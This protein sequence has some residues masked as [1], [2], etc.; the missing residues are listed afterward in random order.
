[1]RA[2][3][4]PTDNSYLWDQEVRLNDPLA[5]VQHQQNGPWRTPGTHLKVH[6]FDMRL[7]RVHSDRIKTILTR[8]IPPKRHVFKLLIQSCERKY[9]HRESSEGTALV[10][11][12]LL[13]RLRGTAFMLTDTIVSYERSIVVDAT[14]HKSIQCQVSSVYFIR[15]KCDLNVVC[16]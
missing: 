10:L 15:L 8:C 3:E 9:S 1:M 14:S 2:A 6:V 16:G 5:S 12:V 11:F 13:K 7:I 4:S